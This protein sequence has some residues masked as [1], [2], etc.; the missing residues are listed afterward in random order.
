MS[1]VRIEESIE[2]GRPVEEVY[3]YL[4]NAQNMPEWAGP[5]QEVRKDTVGPLSEGDRFT[6]VQKFLGRRFE[7][8]CE[9]TA[10][11]PNR[12]IVYR[13]TG[14][15]VPFTFS[16][17][18]EPSA[19]GTR[20]TEIAEGEPGGFFGLVGGLFEKA[21]QRQVRNDLETLK[22]MLESRSS[23]AT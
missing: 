13:S 7:S 11:E 8:P 19:A 22:D 14:G 3:T 5:P 20:F 18:F 17:L 23:P 2:I 4:A 21:G 16:W 6:V 12:R 15:P 1:K 10:A 9:V